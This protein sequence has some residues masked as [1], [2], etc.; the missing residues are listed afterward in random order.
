MEYKVRENA[1]FSNFD[2][3]YTVYRTKSLNPIIY[4][5]GVC[6]NTWTKLDFNLQCKFKSNAI[7]LYIILNLIQFSFK[8]NQ[9]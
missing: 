3:N 4:S 1:L 5:N 2:L 6:I 8:L 9:N 7:L